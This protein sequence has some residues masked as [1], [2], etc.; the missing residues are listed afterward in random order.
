MAG[1]LVDLL[2]TCKQV[3]V[4]L[5]QLPSDSEIQEARLSNLQQLR[6]LNLKRSDYSATPHYCQVQLELPTI[7][8]LVLIKQCCGKRQ[9]NKSAKIN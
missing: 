7:T 8:L 9:L 2:T 1:Y 5:M 6:V 4:F 3:P